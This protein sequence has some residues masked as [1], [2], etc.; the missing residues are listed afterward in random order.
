MFWHEYL[1]IPMHSTWAGLVRILIER[2]E[3][4]LKIWVNWK[5]PD[6]SRTPSLIPSNGKAPRYRALI[7]KTERPRERERERDMESFERYRYIGW[8]RFTEDEDRPE[9]P[10]PYGLTEMRSPDYLFLRHGSLQVSFIC[11]ITSNTVLFT[12]IYV[13]YCIQCVPDWC[14]LQMWQT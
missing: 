4:K 7:E 13:E 6:S 10:R 14:S 1:R 9:K 12:V 2:S 5:D 8:K 3:F 11:L